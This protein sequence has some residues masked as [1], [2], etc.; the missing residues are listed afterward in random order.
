MDLERAAERAAE[1]CEELADNVSML[2][3]R[4]RLDLAEAEG[5]VRDLPHD[6]DTVPAWLVALGIPALAGGL[7]GAMVVGITAPCCGT[8]D[9][10]PPIVVLA[11]LAGTGLVS[12]ITG[13]VWLSVNGAPFRGRDVL[14]QRVE[15]L[16]RILSRRQSR[17]LHLDVGASPGSVVLTVQATF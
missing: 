7:V 2:L 12:L 9:R 8:D 4:A 13:I 10:W 15:A 14:V 3:C 11:T 5:Y 16:E 17:G 6:D 1:R